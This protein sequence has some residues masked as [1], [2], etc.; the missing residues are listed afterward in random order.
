MEKT[1]SSNN[2][3]FFIVMLAVETQSRSGIKKQTEVEM[4]L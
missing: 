1:L 3:A 4:Q 2:P